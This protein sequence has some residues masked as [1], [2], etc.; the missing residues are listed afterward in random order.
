MSKYNEDKL[1]SIIQATFYESKQR[2]GK[3]TKRPPLVALARDFGAEGEEVGRLLAKKL[4]V[5][6]FDQQLLDEIVKK[7]GVD[8][9]LMRQLDERLPSKTEEWVV[10][11][12]SAGKGSREEFIKRLFKTMNG[13]AVSGGVVV[14]RGAQ[15][16]LSKH[17]AFRMR[18]TGSPAL[19]AQRVAAREGLDLEAARQKVDQVNRDRIE[20]VKE[21]FSRKPTDA[22]Y[23]D[24]IISSDRLT[25]EQIAT[26]SVD[27]MKLMGFSVR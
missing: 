2:T 14:G 6:C 23:Y 5:A 24:F 16:I 11:I 26:L 19:C 1:Q 9:G 21:L 12:L 10:D 15:I 22:A 7:A 13:I 17:D 4:G 27:V 25:P 18:V 8:A 3:S 20:F